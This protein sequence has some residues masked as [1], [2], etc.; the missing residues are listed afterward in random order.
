LKARKEAELEQQRRI[1]L[2]LKPTDKP[3][4]INYIKLPDKYHSVG[5]KKRFEFLEKD[6]YNEDLR[7]NSD[8]LTENMYSEKPYFRLFFRPL[9][10]TD[11]DQYLG[12]PYINET[13]R[14]RSTKKNIQPN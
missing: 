11:K 3:S 12:Y 14:S 1:A 8:Y 6:P 4:W 5:D 10:A 13:T 9:R 7:Y 2:N